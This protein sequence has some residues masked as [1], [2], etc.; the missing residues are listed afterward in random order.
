MRN[1]KC[2]LFLYLA[3]IVHDFHC[4]LYIMAFCCTF[5]DLYFALI[6]N[7]VFPAVSPPIF[8]QKLSIGRSAWTPRLSQR[9]YAGA[10]KR[11]CWG[12]LK[13]TRTSLLHFTTLL[14][15]ETTRSVSLKVNDDVLS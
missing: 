2:N 12:Q 9:L 11:T 8:L 4:T 6:V 10:P 15:V 13:A 3:Y 1:K 14:P 5:T 7:V